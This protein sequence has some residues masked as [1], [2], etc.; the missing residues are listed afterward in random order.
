MQSFTICREILWESE[1]AT[2]AEIN[3]KEIEF[4]LLRRSNDPRIGDKQK[5][6]FKS[7]AA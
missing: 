7:K 6:R 2:R 5:A 4:V 1:T 3:T